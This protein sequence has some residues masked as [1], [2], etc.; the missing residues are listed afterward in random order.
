MASQLEAAVES[1]QLAQ[2]DG[3]FEMAPS[4]S[5]RSS[6]RSGGADMGLS[7]TVRHG[8]VHVDGIGMRQDR[9]DVGAGIVG[10][11]LRARRR[12][13]AT[14]RGAERSMAGCGRA[15]CGGARRGGARRGRIG[16]VGRSEAG[17]RHAR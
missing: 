11:G 2:V 9:E 1:L 17:L 14:S 3:P 6:R 4:R 16:P 15:G 8:H 12:R 5:G 7:R 13:Q 10:P